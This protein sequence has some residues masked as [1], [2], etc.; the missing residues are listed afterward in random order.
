[1]GFFN[2]RVWGRTLLLAAAIMAVL[3]G[4]GGEDNTVSNETQQPA[5]YTLQI[6]INPIGGGTVS[7]NPDKSAYSAGERVTVSAAPASGYRFVSWSGVSTST[8]VEV[9]VAMDA[10]L[11]LTANL[12]QMPSDGS[13][14]TVSLGG[15]MWMKKNLNIVTEDSWCYENSSDSCAKYGRLYRWAAAKSACKSVG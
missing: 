15:K 14:E 3:M 4:C 2:R 13:Y 7:R 11:V 12:Q 1:M 10:D 6:S 5:T 9:I 8:Y